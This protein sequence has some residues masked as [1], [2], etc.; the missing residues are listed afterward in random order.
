MRIE[1]EIYGKL[2]GLLI[3]HWITLLGCWHD[4]RRS[5]RQARQMVQWGTSALCFALR[6][7]RSLQEVIVRLSDGMRQG[8]RIDSRR[9]KHN[10]YQ[11]LADPNLIHS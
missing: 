5:L 2:I 4:P 8:C 10:T 1:T 9:K 7:Q 6:E 11:L 3:T